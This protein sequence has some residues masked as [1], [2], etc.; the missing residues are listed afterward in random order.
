MYLKNFENSFLGPILTPTHG[1]SVAFTKI[2]NDIPNNE[3]IIIDT[4]SKSNNFLWKSLANVK[5]LYLIIRKF[6]LTKK[7]YL[8]QH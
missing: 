4:N 8:L 5:I 1:Q 2:C 6:Y 7:M 3:K